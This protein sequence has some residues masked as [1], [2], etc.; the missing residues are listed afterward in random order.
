MST[1]S[2]VV[3]E[4]ETL[5]LTT[6][7]GVGKGENTCVYVSC[8]GGKLVFVGGSS[9]VERIEGEGMLEKVQKTNA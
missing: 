5:M 1:K 3:Q 6:P 7:E 4:G 8:E 9:I 2:V